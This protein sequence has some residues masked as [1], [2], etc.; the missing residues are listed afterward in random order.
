MKIS[1]KYDIPARKLYFIKKYDNL[2]RQYKEKILWKNIKFCD[3]I[4][5][6]SEWKWKI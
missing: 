4:Y 5:E 6:K 3:I 1:T 2:Y